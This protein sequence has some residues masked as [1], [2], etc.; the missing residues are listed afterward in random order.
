MIRVSLLSH[1]ID[2]ILAI[3][4]IVCSYMAML[5]GSVVVALMMVGVYVTPPRPGATVYHAPYHICHGLCAM[6]FDTLAV[7]N[8]PYF[9]H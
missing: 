4:D 8:T 7:H 3:S 5:H 9:M 6:H 2:C 1:T